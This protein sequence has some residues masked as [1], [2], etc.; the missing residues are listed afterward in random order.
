MCIYFH[1]RLYKIT[2]KRLRDGKIIS[3]KQVFEFNLWIEFICCL[4][5]Q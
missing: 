5:K 1:I 4:D 2:K 3:T